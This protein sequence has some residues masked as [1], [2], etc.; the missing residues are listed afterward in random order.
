M[1]KK[2]GVISLVAILFIVMLGGAG[3][4]LWNEVARKPA[5]SSTRWVYLSHGKVEPADALDQRWVRLGLQHYDFD[6]KLKAGRLDGAYR[7][8][9]GMTAWAIARRVISRRQTPV[10]ITFHD[11]RLP[12]QW[13]ARMGE[14]L[15]CDSAELIAALLDPAFLR[16]AETDSAN[17]ISHILPDT[18][19]VY[20]NIGASDLVGRMQKEYRRFWTETRLKQAAAR[21]LTPE[22]V[23]TLASIAEEETQ[24]RRERGVVGLLYWNRLRIGMPLQA[25]P[26]VKFAVGDFALKRILHKHLEV[27]SPYNTYRN[28][29]LPPGPIRMPEKATIDSILNGRDHPYLYMCAKPDFSGRH[30]FATTLNEHLRNAAAYHRALDSKK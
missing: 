9:S 14:K 8:D 1:T 16:E 7:L 13:A 20:W 2:A 25:D 11:I 26:T 27:V 28:P 29:G 22:E 30:N 23:S 18:Y 17:V 21:N 12:Q 24:D 4:W 19:E 10:R 3:V 6:E 15:L 5:I